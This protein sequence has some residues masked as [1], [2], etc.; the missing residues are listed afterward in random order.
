MLIDTWEGIQSLTRV[1]GLIVRGLEEWVPLAV[2]FIRL[3]SL[4]HAC[5]G[6]HVAIWILHQLLRKW[7]KVTFW[8][9]CEAFV[10]R[11]GAYT[12]VRWLLEVVIPSLFLRLSSCVEYASLEQCLPFHVVKYVAPV[13][14]CARMFYRKICTCTHL[15]TKIEYFGCLLWGFGQILLYFLFFYLLSLFELFYG[16]FKRNDCIMTIYPW[17]QLFLI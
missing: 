3:N 4:Q 12:C 17:Y 1:V 13:S 2:G 10:D 9:F 7:P 11:Q 5:T 6:V 15:H 14:W 16:T 8:P